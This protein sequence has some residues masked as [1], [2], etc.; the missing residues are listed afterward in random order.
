MIRIQ[1]NVMKSRFLLIGLILVGLILP[2]R[3]RA[4]FV[5]ELPVLAA[6]GGNDHGVFEI[7]LLQWD[8]QSDPNPVALRWRNAWVALGATHLNSMATAFRYAVERTPHLQHS[9][10]VTVLGV[11][12]TPTSSDGPSAGAAMAV[13]F[14]AMFRGERIQRGVAMTGTLQPEGVIGPVGS[15]PDKIRAAVREGYRTILIPAGQLH[16]PRWNLT[17]L[18]M[19]LNVTIQEVATIDEAYVLMTGRKP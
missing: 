16:E 6:F 8:Q 4:E 12:Y 2:S 9:G 15:I 17:R 1:T 19:E 5:V 18:G 7:L 11:S 14:T 13:G 10:T 3:G